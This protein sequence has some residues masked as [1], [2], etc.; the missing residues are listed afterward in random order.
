MKF[1]SKS[2]YIYIKF[3]VFGSR[4][5]RKLKYY[6]LKIR[7]YSGISPKSIIEHGVGFDKVNPESIIIEDG[8]VVSSGTLILS[9]EHVFSKNKY[10]TII[11][12][13]AY[14]GVRC[15]ILP[16]AVVGRESIIGA[17]SV[18]RRKIPPYAF[19][20]GNPAKV[21]GFKLKPEEI[22]EYERENYP[23]NERIPLEKLE[24][25][26]SKYFLNRLDEIKE[27]TKI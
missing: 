27:F 21:V 1:S 24:R 26:Y 13:N 4:I 23:E 11:E 18:I 6:S 20:T 5:V 7:G 22:I 25:D 14:I 17:C 19:V 15:T 2:K 3:L 8:A 12:K 9:H 16:G 10:T